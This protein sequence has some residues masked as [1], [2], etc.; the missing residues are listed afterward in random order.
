MKKT[1]DDFGPLYVREKYRELKALYEAFIKRSSEIG[2]TPE[3]LETLF[4]E[5][6][7]MTVFIEPPQSKLQK[8]TFS[9]PSL[10]EIQKKDPVHFEEAKV[11]VTS[12]Y[13]AVVSPE[14]LDVLK[15]ECRLVF[16]FKNE[17]LLWSPKKEGVQNYVDQVEEDINRQKKNLAQ[18]LV[19]FPSITYEQVQAAL[20]FYFE[21]I[22]EILSQE[23]SQYYVPLEAFAAAAEEAKGQ[24]VA[25]GQ[26]QEN[27][28]PAD[29]VLAFI[30]FCDRIMLEILKDR[31]F[32]HLELRKHQWEEKKISYP[33]EISLQEEWIE[34]GQGYEIPEIEFLSFYGKNPKKP[35]DQEVYYVRQTSRPALYGYQWLEVRAERFLDFDFEKLRAALYAQNQE[36]IRSLIEQELLQKYLPYIEIHGASD[37]PLGRQDLGL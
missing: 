7:A 4:R 18:A 1:R 9:F 28:T 8:V 24:Y 37:F 32:T 10:K 31:I 14:F 36:Q 19:E 11:H 23:K 27:P 17:L 29:A 21:T 26:P 2:V 25:L 20:N 35:G 16:E 33:A 22:R 15:T 5:H 30:E 34:R 6:P 12:F 3:R 13:Q